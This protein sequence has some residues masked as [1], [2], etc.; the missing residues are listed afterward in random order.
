MSKKLYP[1]TQMN[2]IYEITPEWLKSRGVKALI[3]DLDDTLTPYYDTTPND[4]LTEWI[5]RMR[6]NGIRLCILTNGKKKRVLPF[7]KRL[8]VEC[9]PMA[10]KPLPVGYFRALRKLGVKRKEAVA[11]GDQIFTDI[12]G[13]NCAGIHTLLVEPIA[14]KT[15]AV[16][17]KKRKYEKRFRHAQSLQAD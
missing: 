7:C 4:R 8:G 10:M 15:S 3:C 6:E 9:V 2:N 16:E 17:K 12:A 1:V 14:Y 5:R 11:V 13:G